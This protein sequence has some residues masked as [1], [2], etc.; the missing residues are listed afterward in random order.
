MY[1]AILLLLLA[2]LSAWAD[3]NT[4]KVDG[5][6]AAELAR[7][8]TPAFSVAVVSHGR[9]LLS[10]G[11]GL[12]NVE[13]SAPAGPD[14][15]YELLSLGKQFTASAVMLL[16]KGGKVSLDES[17]RTY[18]PDTPAEW[19]PVTVRHLLSHTSG[20]RDYTD[21]P[22]WRES[23]RQDRTPQEL[24]KTVYGPP[25]F[26][27]GSAWRYSNSNYYALGLL[28]EK[29]SGMSYADFLTK[30]IFATLAM[31]ATRLDDYDDIVP[32]RAAGYH[33]NRDKVFNAPYVSPTQKW[34]AGAIL[35]TA[36]DLAKWAVALDSGSLLDAG[37]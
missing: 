17:I 24:L 23:I 29:V 31:T 7:S 16:V 28:I 33:R 22:G 34:A 27:P 19:K 35:S 30:N 15:A 26:A 36:D 13:W 32:H 21:V 11:Y 10:K 3:A 20:I 9:V 14:T 4:D 8:H 6:V 2:A 25:Q 5:L 12:A 1:R 18:L 37:T